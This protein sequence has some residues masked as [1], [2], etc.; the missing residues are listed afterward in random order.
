MY[1]KVVAVFTLILISLTVNAQS[2]TGFIFRINPNVISLDNPQDNQDLLKSLHG[3]LTTKNNDLYKNDYWLSSDFVA[4][5]APYK[6]LYFIEMSGKYQD[7]SFYKP[8]LA[9]I[10][11]LSPAGSYLLKLAFISQHENEPPVLRAIYNIVAVKTAAGFRFKHVLSTRT[12][13]WTTKQVAEVK[14][15]YPYTF[16]P[17][18]ADKTVAFNHQLAQ[19][20][21]VMPIAF[22]YYK[23]IDRE[24]MYRI[25][26]WDYEP[27]IIAD[28]TGG[29]AEVERRIL[30]SGN[31]SEWYPHEVVHLYI[32]SIYAATLNQAIGEGYPTYLGGSA[33]QPLAWHLHQLADFYAAHPERSIMAD[34]E[35]GY[36]VNHQSTVS[37]AIG[38][39]ICQLADERY[40]W[41]GVKKLLMAG[42]QYDDFYRSVT[43]LLQV[44]KMD[45]NDFIRRKFVVY[46][47]K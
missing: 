12:A 39:L 4:N 29:L 24:Q 28:T 43:E 5:Q 31:N 19:R 47:K 17:A 45:F 6:D 10:Q 1:T 32:N 22:T 30:F 25:Q 35:S 23:C 36:D 2:D 13:R 26:G 34:M 44:D 38:G 14:F 16:D 9:G 42:K 7:P 3:F 20:F 11:T 46:T 33:G 40:G 15:V 27:R 21:G 37:Y 8:V 18:I 41:E